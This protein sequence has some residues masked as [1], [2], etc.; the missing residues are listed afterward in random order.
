[1]RNVFLE[2]F[3]FPLGD[4]VLGTS[5]INRLNE[6]RRISSFSEVELDK[7]HRQKLSKILT[8]AVSK[9]SYYKALKIKLHEDPEKT[10]KQFPILTKSLLREECDNLLIG[11]KARCILYQTSGSSGTPTKVYVDKE[12]ESIFRAILIGWWEWTGYRLGNPILQTGMTHRRGFVKTVKDF[13]TSTTYLNAFNLEKSYVVSILN[14]LREKPIHYLGGYASSLY[15]IAKIAKEEG[16]KIKFNSAICWGDKMF[17]HYRQTIEEVFN[18]K[19]YENYACNEGIMIGQKVDLPYYYIYTPNV[20]VEILDESWNEVSDGELGRV[21]VTKLDGYAMPMIRY[22]TGDLAIRL[23]REQY[24]ESR[25][26]NFPLL[27]QVV[28][29]DTD[30]IFTPEGQYFIVHTF[31]GIFAKFDQIKQFRIIQDR[32][33]SINIEYIT[34]LNFTS[35]ILKVIER[36]FVNK[37]ATKLVINWHEVAEIPTGKSGKPQIIQNNLV[38]K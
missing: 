36:E 22:Y 38:T 3:L 32:L 34:G 27:K 33:D 23:P 31:T 12:E 13:V 28:G 18:T 20:H 25:L 8:Y 15:L 6:V 9:S 17:D 4:V 2:K 10:L 19:V 11:D 16:I 21:V 30:L 29:R 26:Y 24:P 14:K 5:F 37:T 1:M 35:E 7:L